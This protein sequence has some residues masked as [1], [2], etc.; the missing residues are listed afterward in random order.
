MPATAVM[1]VRLIACPWPRGSPARVGKYGLEEYLEAKA[2][3]GFN[4]A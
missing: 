3:A 4:A 1:V 2:I